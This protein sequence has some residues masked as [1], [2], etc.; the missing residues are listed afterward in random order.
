MPTLATRRQLLMPEH[1]AQIE[2]S[3]NGVQSLQCS[4]IHQ[5]IIDKGM[6]K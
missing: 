3:A 6:K 2:Y 5:Q 4:S 1:K